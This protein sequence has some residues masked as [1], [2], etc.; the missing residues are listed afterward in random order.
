MQ[1]GVPYYPEHWPRERWNR[2]AKLM[3]EAGVS[4]VRLGEFAWSVLEP[5]QGEYTTE[6]LK[7]AIDLFEK[8]EIGVILCTP[9]PTYPAWL[10]RAYPDIHQVKADG[11]VVEYGQRQD[12]CKNHPGYREAAFAVTDRVVADLGSHPNIKAWQTDNEFGCHGT[13]RCF[14]ECCEKEFQ[15]WLHRRRPEPRTGPRLLSVLIGRADRVPAPPHR[16]H[17]R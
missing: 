17:Q 8:H 12:A 3:R 6:W 10:H 1:V 4:L 13:A 7:E 11:K 5:R 2:D 16:D 15:S 14:C 9:T